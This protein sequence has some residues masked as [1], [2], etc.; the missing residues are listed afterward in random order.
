MWFDKSNTIFNHQITDQSIKIKQENY[1]FETFMKQEMKKD[2]TLTNSVILNR[3]AIKYDLE[4]NND[5]INPN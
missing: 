3:L 1:L 2:S 4:I 5:V